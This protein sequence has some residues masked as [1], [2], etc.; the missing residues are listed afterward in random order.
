MEIMIHAALQLIYDDEL[1]ILADNGDLDI[2][3]IIILATE[4]N[5]IIMKDNQIWSIAKIIL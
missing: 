2:D 4:R 5:F 3:R 1:F